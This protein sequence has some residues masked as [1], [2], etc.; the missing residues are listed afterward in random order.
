MVRRTLIVLAFAAV[1]GCDDAPIDPGPGNRVRLVALRSE[2]VK[3]DTIELRII[4]RTGLN[5]HYTGFFCPWRVQRLHDTVWET[6]SQQEVCPASGGTMQP[7]RIYPLQA[8]VDQTYTAGI[9]RLGV[10]EPLPG[11]VLNNPLDQDVP[12]G[13]DWFT[14]S[15]AFTIRAS[16]EGEQ[17]P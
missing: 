11:N 14:Y 6:V 12:A 9:Y 8:L 16:V 2:Y 15:Q 10:P 1:L 3:G 7:H 5:L 4:N 17:V 13:W